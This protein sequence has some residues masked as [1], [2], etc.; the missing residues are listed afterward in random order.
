MSVLFKRCIT[1]P[2]IL[3]SSVF[4]NNF[5]ICLLEVVNICLRTRV[6]RQLDNARVA[7]IQVVVRQHSLI[8]VVID[9]KLI[10]CVKSNTSRII[11]VMYK[12][13]Q[14]LDTVSFVAS[15]LLKFKHC[16]FILVN[17][18]HNIIYR[19]KTLPRLFYMLFVVILF[20]VPHKSD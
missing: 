5:S 19:N 12:A 6:C 16:I 10:N 7:S 13:S 8:G 4:G 1:I 2:F 11:G 17:A 9:E 14:V 18:L 20:C 3:N 15:T